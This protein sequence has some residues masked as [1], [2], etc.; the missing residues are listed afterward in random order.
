MQ[1]AYVS[2]ERNSDSQDGHESSTSAEGF[3]KFQHES[4][5]GDAHVSSEMDMHLNDKSREACTILLTCICVQ[6][7]N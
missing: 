1:A 2:T 7:H 3:L 4:S 6:F 5:P